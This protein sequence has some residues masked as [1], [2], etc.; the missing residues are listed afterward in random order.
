MSN[1]E[2]TALSFGLRHHIPTK[3]KDVAIEVEFEQ[4][5]QG[6]LRNL[7]HIPDNELTL[8]KTKLRSTC[9]KY[10]K[11]NLLYKYKKVIYNLSINKN[12]VILKQDKGRGIVRLDTTEYTEKCMALLNT[13]YFKRLTTDPTAATERKID[14]VL[15]KIKSK[16]SEQEYKRLYP[17]GSAP[18][19][20]Y[21]TA[22]LHKLKNDIT[23]D[24][25]PIRPIMSNINTASYQLAKYLAKLLSPLSTSEYTVK[26]TSD[27]ITH[28]KGQN[29]P[30][31]FKLISFDVTSLFTNVPLDFTID[32]ILKRIYDENEVNTNI[33]KQQ[34]RDLLLL[35][36]KN[37]HFSYNGDISTQ[38]DGVAMGSPLGPVLAGIFMVE[39]E[40]TI[41]PTLREHMNPWKRYVDDTIYLLH[42]RRIY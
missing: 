13:E 12:F 29:V 36:T 33:P 31:N 9:E 14:K 6:L 1:E 32:V 26:S 20:F 17:A 4:F 5:Y 7:T 37:V 27:F 21:G 3:S 8:L 28:I 35:C 39:L 34:M 10:S 40:R 22:K 15:R 18:A 2:Y 38:A 30:N 24:D 11:I 42:K 16:F 19:R 23:F 41:L 25:L